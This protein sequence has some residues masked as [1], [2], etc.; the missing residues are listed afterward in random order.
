[1]KFVEEKTGGTVKKFKGNLWNTYPSPIVGV[2][3]ATSL[4]GGTMTVTLDAPYDTSAPA[5]MQSHP[6]ILGYLGLPKSGMFQLSTQ[7]GVQGL[8]FYYNQ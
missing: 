8:T 3:V 6:D 5:V 7:S 2:K 1:M 4:S